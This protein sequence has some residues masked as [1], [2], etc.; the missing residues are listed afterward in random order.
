MTYTQG[1][2]MSN[3]RVV[4]VMEWE[5]MGELPERLR[6]AISKI[7]NCNGQSNCLGLREASSGKEPCCAKNGWLMYT[8]C[9]ELWHKGTHSK[10]F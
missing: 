5:A 4:G 8:T 2:N 7:R 6:M 3:P 1:G 9:R 10:L